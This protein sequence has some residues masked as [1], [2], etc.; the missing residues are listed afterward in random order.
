MSELYSVL[1]DSK[2]ALD[3]SD[4]DTFFNQLSR[5][6]TN[7]IHPE[8]EARQA[9]SPSQMRAV[10][11]QEVFGLVR[12]AIHINED[13][14]QVFRW[15]GI[16]NEVAELVPKD[17][18]ATP[19]QKRECRDKLRGILQ[20]KGGY[21]EFR[22]WVEH[23]E[24]TNGIPQPDIQAIKRSRAIVMCGIEKLRKLGQSSE[25]SRLLDEAD[26]AYMG[27]GPYAPPGRAWAKIE[28][29][30]QQIFDSKGGE[31][32]FTRWAAEGL[33]ERFDMDEDEAVAGPS[34]QG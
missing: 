8:P 15:Q 4:W 10:N 31:V 30:H 17:T 23:E 6:L 19:E 16:L 11:S 28:A 18:E 25:W 7:Q 32:A 21:K 13:F 1:K 22:Q 33:W 29:V 12:R 9:P 34:S 5:Q 24:T 2:S 14:P 20:E 3:A 27:P 26:A